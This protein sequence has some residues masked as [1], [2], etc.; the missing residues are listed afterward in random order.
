MAEMASDPAIQA[1]KSAMRLSVF[2]ARFNRSTAV[3]T[4]PR[5]RA[6]SAA[7]TAAPTA[8]TSER[9]SPAVRTGKRVED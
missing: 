2:N 9:G 4:L 5:A 1:E 7:R 3:S 6:G 8:E